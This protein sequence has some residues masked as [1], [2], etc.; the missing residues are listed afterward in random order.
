MIFIMIANTYQ[1]KVINGE[2]FHSD[3]TNVKSFFSSE[4]Y[5]IYYKF[6]GEWKL[7][8]YQNILD[9]NVHQEEDRSIGIIVCS[10][11]VINL[12]LFISIFTFLRKGGCCY[13][14]HLQVVELVCTMCITKMTLSFLTFSA[15]HVLLLKSISKG[16]F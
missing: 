7:L 13:E 2:L 16:S 5:I 11:T 15:L 1:D 10:I 14:S 3:I 4:S 9:D 6:K 12:S 8:C